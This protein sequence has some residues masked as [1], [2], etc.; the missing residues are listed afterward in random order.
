MALICVLCFKLFINV[1][2]QIPYSKRTICKIKLDKIYINKVIPI[3][4]FA[5]LIIFNAK[6]A[7]IFNYCYLYLN[8]YITCSATGKYHTYVLHFKFPVRKNEKFLKIIS[9][10]LH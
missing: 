5:L 3:P 6:K 9:I 1:I 10:Q 7:Q 4:N 2:L 8:I